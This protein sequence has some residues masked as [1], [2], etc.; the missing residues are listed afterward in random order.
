MTSSK[1][2][3]M[4]IDK[5]QDASKR[6]GYLKF[7]LGFAALA[8]IMLTEPLYRD[9]LYDEPE[10]KSITIISKNVSEPVQKAFVY[11]TNTG[12]GVTL[13]LYTLLLGIGSLNRVKFLYYL[14]LSSV[15]VYVM[16][17]TKMLYKHDRPMWVNPDVSTS[18]ITKCSSN[19]GNP[20][21]HSM[22]ASAIAFTVLCDILGHLNTYQN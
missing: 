1:I 18:A 5:Q 9:S 15:T 14:L 2:S 7:I 3:P 10:F 20:S 13:A 6:Y 19:Y 17:I 11:F 12:G 8:A 22:V 21:G 16:N 4:E